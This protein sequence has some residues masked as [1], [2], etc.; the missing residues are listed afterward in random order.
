MWGKFIQF[1][2]SI[3]FF[4]VSFLKS[5]STVNLFILHR[6]KPNFCF[7]ET[8]TW[9]LFFPLL[10]FVKETCLNQQKNTCSYL[11]KTNFDPNYQL[12]AIIWVTTRL[13]FAKNLWHF[14]E[15]LSQM[16]FTCIL[17][18]ALRYWYNLICKHLFVNVAYTTAAC[19]LLAYVILLFKSGFV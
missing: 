12:S 15:R 17:R 19:W 5:G 11:I 6:L 10:V 18:W 8:K 1:R 2:N 7:N 3:S 13:I 16:C 9:I 14:T 4:I